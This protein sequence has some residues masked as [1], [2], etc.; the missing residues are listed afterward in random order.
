MNGMGWMVAWAGMVFIASAAG[1]AASPEAAPDAAADQAAFAA[2]ES[3]SRGWREAFFDAGTGDWK[4]KWFLDGQIAAVTNSRKGM[5]IT[6]GP[7]LGDNAHHAVLWTQESFAG[8]LRIEFDFTRLDFESRAVNILYIQAT[9]SGKPPYV[10]DITQWSELR[11]VPEMRQ[12]HSH[13][14]ALHISFA[15][16]PNANDPADDYVRARRY[17]PEGTGL[18]GSDLKPDYLRTGLFAPG[19]A[20]HFIVIKQG[21]HLYMQVKND[22]KTTCFHWHND[23]LPPIE[24]GRIGLRLMASRSSLFKDFRVSVAQ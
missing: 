21:N 17:M 11:K 2:A 24:Q 8:D 7:R 13:M 16:Y 5:Q 3:A 22:Q 1:W 9:G 18:R 23:K 10:S 20:H 12:Y 15:S 14:H 19:V 4:A 6:A